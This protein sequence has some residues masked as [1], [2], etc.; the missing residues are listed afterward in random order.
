MDHLAEVQF[1]HDERLHAAGEIASSGTGISYKEYVAFGGPES[2]GGFGT[3]ATVTTTTDWAEFPYFDGKEGPGFRART[4]AGM[5]S[6]RLG[7]RF[8]SV[9]R[10]MRRNQRGV[11]FPCP[12]DS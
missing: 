11:S 2:S 1:G 5:G 10:I 6:G 12:V 9:H 8:S 7:F 4:A 3:S